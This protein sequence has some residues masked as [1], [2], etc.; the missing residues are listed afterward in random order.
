MHLWGCSEV[1]QKSI[2][3]LYDAPL[4]NTLWK[5]FRYLSRIWIYY[6]RGL[7][8]HCSFF[9]SRWQSKTTVIENGILWIL[10]IQIEVNASVCTLRAWTHKVRDFRKD[11]QS[12]LVKIFWW[13]LLLF[14]TQKA[15]Y[16]WRSM[17]TIHDWF[18]YTVENSRFTDKWFNIRYTLRCLECSRV[19]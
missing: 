19:H 12:F 10:Y 3:S 18:D 8:C 16:F 7:S 17:R 9:E 14:K 15:E 13:I 6:V 4:N 5:L 11:W 2:P 1:V